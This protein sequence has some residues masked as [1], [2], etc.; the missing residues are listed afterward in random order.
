MSIEKLAAEARAFA[1]P[2]TMKFRSIE[3]RRGLV[4]QGGN[5]WGEFAPFENYDDEISGRWLAGALESA[6]GDWPT[7]VRTTVPVNAIIPAVEE[8]IAASLAFRAVVEFGLTTLKVKVAE[9]GQSA[10]QDLLRL[11]AIRLQLSDLN[12]PEVN[13]RIDVNGGWTPAQAIELISQYELAAGGLEYVEQP[14]ATLADC[15]LVKSE[16]N[17][18]IAIDEGL[19]LAKQVDPLAIRN[20][21]DL[22]VVKSLP[23]GGVKNALKAI[24]EI[25]L[26]VVV[27][28]SLDTSIGLTS[29]LV[30]ASCVPDL[31][32]A[33]GLGTGIL[34]AEDLV[35]KPLL[36]KNGELTVTIPNPDSVLLQKA[37]QRVSKDEETAWHE[38]M[39]R[40]WYASGAKLVSDRVRE[41]VEQ[42]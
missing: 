11:Q 2:L 12:L 19:R 9:P 42:W 34:F 30:L 13:I 22:L 5:G 35:E 4:F 28:G 31:A 7:P 8:E 40:A 3:T 29:G 20:S 25:G 17:V 38:R 18:R 15:A 14:C 27:S 26:P 32:G 6:F 33:C 37:N 21:A 1:L 23:M 41:A 16:V 36:P 39:V 10:S 24:S